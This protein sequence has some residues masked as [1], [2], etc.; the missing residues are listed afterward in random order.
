MG[1]DKIA[2]AKRFL[3][4]LLEMPEFNEYNKYIT[5]VFKNSTHGRVEV[6]ARGRSRGWV[7]YDAVYD[8]PDY[9]IS[10]LKSLL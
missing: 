10:F 5:G 6:L 3:S 2:H 9:T 8:N 1:Y 4:S 7:D